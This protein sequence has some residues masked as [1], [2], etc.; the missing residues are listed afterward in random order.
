MNNN[1]YIR[2]IVDPTG[3]LRGIRNVAG[4][5]DQ[6]EGKASKAGAFLKGIFAIGV[7]AT[8]G[9]AIIKYGDAYS[10]LEAKIRQA[11]GKNDDLAESMNKTF[12]AANRART[13]VGSFGK[14]VLAIAGATSNMNLGFDKSVRM[15]ETLAKMMRLGGASTAEAHS[16]VLQYGQALRK[17]KLDGDEFRSVME[18]SLPVQKALAKSLGISTD[19]LAKFSKQGKI[20]RQVMVDA[21]IG[22]ADEVDRQFAMMSMKVSDAWTVMQNAATK[23]FGEM[24]LSERIAP[25]ILFI[26]DNFDTV[27]K[28]AMVLANILGT[29]LVRRGIFLAIQG[30]KSLALFAAANPFTVLL[31]AIVA[32]T[33]ALSVFGR[34][35]SVEYGSLATIGDFLDALGHNIKEVFSSL[36]DLAKEGFA[37]VINVFG[38]VVDAADLSFKDIVVFFA[39]MG[40]AIGKLAVFIGQ[41]VTESFKDMGLAAGEAIIDAANYAHKAVKGIL[42]GKDNGV[43]GGAS[44]GWDDFELHGG[45]IGDVA[46]RKQSKRQTDNID[47][48]ALRDLAETTAGFTADQFKTYQDETRKRV[49]EKLASP[50]V[51]N[52]AQRGAYFKVLARTYMA[53]DEIAAA[54][55]RANDAVGTDVYYNPLRGARDKA[56]QTLQNNYDQL[57]NGEAGPLQKGIEKTF[58]DAEANAYHRMTHPDKKKKGLMEPGQQGE[59]AET[60]AQRQAREKASREREQA[61]KQYEAL[62]SSISPVYKAE[63]ELSKAQEILNEA[64]AYGFKDMNGEVLTHDSIVRLMEKKKELLEDQL[65]PYGAMIRQMERDIIATRSLSGEYDINSKVIEERNKKRKEGI[66]LSDAEAG[67]LRQLMELQKGLSDRQNL[68]K[69]YFDKAGFVSPEEQKTRALADTEAIYGRNDPRFGAEVD[70]INSTNYAPMFETKADQYARALMLVEQAAKAAG[71]SM[72]GMK[73]LIAAVNEEFGKEPK[74]SVWAQGLNTYF[75]SLPDTVETVAQAVQ[76]AFDTMSSAIVEFV[77]TGKID[78]DSFVKN[79]LAA[80]ARIVT[81]AMVYQLLKLL[82]GFFGGPGGTAGLIVGG[83][84]GLMEPTYA[85]DGGL[86]RVGGSGSTDNQFVPMMLT[87]GEHLQVYPRGQSPHS[88]GSGSGG[89]T[90]PTTVVMVVRDEREAALAVAQSPRG[91]AV[92][93]ANLRQNPAHLRTLT[94]GRG[95]S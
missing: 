74:F 76:Q 17:G 84:N 95:Q 35:L 11:S 86:W 27:G 40:D 79:T 56:K 12:R 5:L 25:A 66:D 72:E 10:D 91:A 39:A 18:N 64:M 36:G 51:Q 37:A 6:L 92:Q 41:T 24:H 34:E 7:A 60:S 58:D 68:V 33:A 88:G 52:D 8:A 73:P 46:R 53:Q 28:A 89:G 4:A 43:W 50:D 83:V 65:D 61:L 49:E 2:V 80:F 22:S 9:R 90:P 13:D 71:L 54:A 81:D 32:A 69:G 45:N 1:Y 23:F 19:E 75:Q 57:T 44:V 16:T 93:M 70:K 47:A 85:A 48:A 30:L 55:K 78:M 87:P 3:A 26:A 29:Y 42:Y 21:L 15:T 77:S 82:S 14:T 59:A 67:K 20:T 31:Y 63:L 62:L 94:G 38:E